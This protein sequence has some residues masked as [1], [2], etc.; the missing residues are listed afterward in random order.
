MIFK[1]VAKYSL[2]LLQPSSHEEDGL[3]MAS[4][5]LLVSANDEDPGGSDWSDWV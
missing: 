3:Y 1:E 5:V 2:Q 4:F